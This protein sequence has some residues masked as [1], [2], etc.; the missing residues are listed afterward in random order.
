MAVRQRVIVPFAGHVIGEGFNSKTVERVGKG[1]VA[2][3]E[4]EDELAPGQSASF[5]FLMLTS[6]DSLE[7]ALNIGA[8]IDA[9]YGLFS[10]GAK[11]DFAENSAINTTSTYVLASCVVTNALRSGSD[12]NPTETADRLIKKGDKAAWMTAFGDRFTQALQTGGEFHSLVRVTSS[13]TEH[14]RSI[15]AS[16]HAELNGLVTSG[17][18]EASFR[19]AEKDTSARTEVDIQ[20]HQTGGVGAEVQIPGTDAAKIRAHMNDFAKAAHAN[21][22]AFQAELLTYDTLALPFPSEEEEEQRREVLE[23]CLARRQRYWSAISDLTFAQSENAP[24]IFENLPSREKLLELQNEY[25]R[26][27]NDLMAHAR[28]VAAGTIPPD[29]FVATAEPVLPLFKRR[30]SGSF[31]SWWAR[32]KENDPGLLQDERTLI[33]AIASQA[34]PL[35]AV[36]IDQAPPEAVERAAN[37]IDR[38][39]V[40]TENPPQLTSMASL[41]KMIDAPLQRMRTGHAAMR[42]LNGLEPFSRLE[43]FAHTSGRLRDLKGI[44][45]AAG[46]RTLLLSE[47][48]IKDLTPLLTLL[49]LEQLVIAGNEV[50]TLEPLR[51]LARLKCV[52]VARDESI[53]EEHRFVDNPIVDARALGALSHLACPISTADRLDVKVFDSPNTG[54][55]IPVPTLIQSGPATRIGDSNRFKFTP[56]DGSTSEQLLCCGLAEF[57]DVAFV[58]APIVV[59]GA[60]LPSRGFILGAT[61]P[62]DRSQSLPPTDLIDLWFGESDLMSDVGLLAG[63]VLPNTLVE[64]TPAA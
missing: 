58:A 3:T 2:S 23:D 28:G 9:R 51:G 64:I 14:Q 50:E 31:A 17:S 62:D 33:G 12:F 43:L 37:Q 63:S 11:F 15:S 22:A 45:A 27:L 1:L 57:F 52:V 25:R 60:S 44:S 49:E 16:L 34:A 5:K 35:L 54:F 32:A 47:N 55:D 38:L 46:L 20:V 30:T 53:T 29:L 6:Q 59:Y 39:F 8:Q 24:M 21:A 40:D 36:P 10:C 7:K 26:V 19:T 61:N 41:P 4:G 18:F 56:D 48:A 13:K 42:D